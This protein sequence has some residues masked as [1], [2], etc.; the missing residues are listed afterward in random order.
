MNP[1]CIWWQPLLLIF[2]FT[3]AAFVTARCLQH[4]YLIRHHGLSAALIFWILGCISLG[5]SLVM[6]FF[7][8]KLMAASEAT[9]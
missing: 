4:S 5:V 7:N 6:I 8:V 2:F 1:M 9:R 3:P